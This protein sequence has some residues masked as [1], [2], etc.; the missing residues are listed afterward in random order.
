MYGDICPVEQF[1]FYDQARTCFAVVQTL[2][3]RP[4]ANV[5]LQKEVIGPD[6]QDLKP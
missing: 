5:I 4:Y 1:S 6:G 3:Q 2:E